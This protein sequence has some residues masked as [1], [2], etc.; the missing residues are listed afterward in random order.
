LI[1][2]GHVFS[3]T[4]PINTSIFDSEFS[5][6]TLEVENPDYDDQNQFLTASLIR[7]YR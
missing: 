7:G 4:Q 5:N 6:A 3:Q 1:G 2:S